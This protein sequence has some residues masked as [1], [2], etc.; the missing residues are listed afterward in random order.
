MLRLK[1]KKKCLFL[2]DQQIRIGSLTVRVPQ[3]VVLLP[4]FF[5]IYIADMLVSKD[6]KLHPNPTSEAAR[7]IW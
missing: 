7:S 4:L 6:R 3:G 5:N 1:Y 2:V